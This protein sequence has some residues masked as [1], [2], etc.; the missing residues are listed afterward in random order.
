[1]L[2]LSIKNPPDEAYYHD[3]STNR[4]V[5]FLIITDYD[6]KG[7]RIL[8]AFPGKTIDICPFFLFIYRKKQ[9]I[10]AIK[11]ARHP[12]GLVYTKFWLI[13]LGTPFGQFLIRSDSPTITSSR[14]APGGT[15]GHTL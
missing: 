13:T 4:K 9:E 6:K 11:K 3:S 12:A 1:M 7:S 2:K 5:L 8:T 14:A 10:K 15:I